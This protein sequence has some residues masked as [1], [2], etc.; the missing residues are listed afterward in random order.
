MTY[1]VVAVPDVEEAFRKLKKKDTVRFEQVMKKLEEIGREPEIGKPLRRP[2]QGRWR[3][4]IGHFVLIYTLN[5]KTETVT[6]VKF[7]HHD[8]AY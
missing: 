4:H 1:T 5:P 7:G 8:D 6:L 3:I 2:L